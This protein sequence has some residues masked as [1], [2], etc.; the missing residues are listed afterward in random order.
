MPGGIETAMLFSF[1]D[2]SVLDITKS[3]QQLEE[4]HYAIRAIVACAQDANIKLIERMRKGSNGLKEIARAS[5]KQLKHVVQLPPHADL[6]NMTSINYAFHQ[7]RMADA[8]Q[9]YRDHTERDL[10]DLQLLR[11]QTA[12]QASLIWER[13]ADA[14]LQ[15]E[16]SVSLTL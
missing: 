10:E 11:E 14:N 8:F 6:W 13:T 12:L 3:R 2:Q 4:D 7:E 9:Q 15:D 1:F 5:L 16:R